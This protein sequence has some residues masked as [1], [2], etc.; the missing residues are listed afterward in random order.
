MPDVMT[1]ACDERRDL[2]DFLGTLTPEQWETQS[3]CEDWT[4]RE[5]TVHVVSYEGL[6]SAAPQHGWCAAGS[7]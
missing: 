6:A 2:A 4:I 5:V 3:L 7:A 1:L